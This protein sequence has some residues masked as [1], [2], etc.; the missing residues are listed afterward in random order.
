MEADE[1]PSNSKN[2]VG[3]NANAKKPKKDVQKVVKGEVVLRPPSIGK[4]IKGIF[5]GGEFKGATRYIFGEVLI[6]AMKNMFVDAATQGVERVV[7]GDR[8]VRRRGITPMEYGRPRISY[9]RIQDRF[10]RQSTRS[11]MLPDQPPRF[12]TSSRPRES[13]IILADRQDAEAVL[14]QLETIVD[15]YNVVSVGDL[16]DM[17]GRPSSH[18]DMKWGWSSLN[19]SRIDQVRNGYLLTLPPVEPI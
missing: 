1:F 10:E 11:A 12:N 13:D 3:D 15:T 9:D 5:F 16:Q 2:P 7:Y 8:Q 18:T 17:L 4:R 14:D 19:G 6:P